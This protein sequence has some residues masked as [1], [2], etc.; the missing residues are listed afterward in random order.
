MHAVDL[1]SHFE[2]HI[3][4][5]RYQRLFHLQRM[6]QFSVDFLR[7]ALIYGVRIARVFEPWFPDDY[8]YMRIYR[9]LISKED[10]QLVAVST[11]DHEAV[12]R[13]SDNDAKWLERLLEFG[14][15]IYKHDG[16]EEVRHADDD[17]DAL[18]LDVGVDDAAAGTGASHLVLL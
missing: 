17:G 6:Q 14:E 5:R 7:N 2:R 3:N 10:R 16:A 13:L 8:A 18:G 9:M 1:A 15:V 4:W 11:F 12:V